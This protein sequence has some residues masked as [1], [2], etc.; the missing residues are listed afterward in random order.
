[1]VS[2]SKTSR[3]GGFGPRAGGLGGASPPGRRPARRRATPKWVWAREA[4][5]AA[6]SISVQERGGAKA[7]N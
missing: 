3:R 2:S 4:S 6:R 1:M 5:V 7:N